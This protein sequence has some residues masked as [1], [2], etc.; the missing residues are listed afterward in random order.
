MDFRV[1]FTGEKFTEFTGSSS[2]EVRDFGILVVTD[3]SGKRLHLS[4]AGWLA[5]EDQEPQS[6]H[7]RFATDD[8]HTVSSERD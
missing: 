7:A 4:P 2:Y 5:V 6:G 8:S 1:T 3:E